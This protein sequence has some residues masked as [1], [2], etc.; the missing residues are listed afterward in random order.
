[1]MKKVNNEHQKCLIDIIERDC[2]CSSFLFPLNRNATE[3]L[4]P[5]GFI[6]QVISDSKR[7]SLVDRK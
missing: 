3:R 2:E 6:Q 1:M 4:K 5:C 7:E